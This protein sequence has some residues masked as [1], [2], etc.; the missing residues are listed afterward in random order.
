MALL[1]MAPVGVTHPTHRWR[2]Y[3]NQ[4]FGTLAEVPDDLFGTARPADNG[5]GA[6]W[7]ARGGARLR[8]FGSWNVLEETPASYDAFLRN[9]RSGRY[10]SVTYKVTRR[11]LLI[12]SGTH[13]GMVF[14]ER[15]AFGDPSGA[16]HALVLDYPAT[17]RSTFDPIV[18]RLSAS[19]RW[20]PG[21]AGE[22]IRRL[23]QAPRRIPSGPVRQRIRPGSRPGCIVKVGIR[24]LRLCS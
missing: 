1:A 6:T 24:H 8:I 22:R 18:A 23:D 20:T 9:G 14:Y 17:A 12:L 2:I 16:I 21:R 4:R 15:Y 7:T 10:A 3:R 5:D 19:L 11:D 13:Q